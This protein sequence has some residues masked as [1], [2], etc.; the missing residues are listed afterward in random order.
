MT[1]IGSGFANEIESSLDILLDLVEQHVQQ[2]APFAVF[3]KV[4]GVSIFLN[5]SFSFFIKY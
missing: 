2:M 1:H 4:R 5:V 3:V